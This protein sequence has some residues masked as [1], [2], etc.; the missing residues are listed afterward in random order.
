MVTMCPESETTAGGA[1]VAVM[2]DTC[3]VRAYFEPIHIEAAADMCAC[4][5][6][7]ETGLRVEGERAG[8]WAVAARAA[9]RTA[10]EA[11]VG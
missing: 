2:A 7:A 1:R 10:A 9:T 8:L 3:C 6:K 4:A 11:A 5:G